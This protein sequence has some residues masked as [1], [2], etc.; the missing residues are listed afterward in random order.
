M[1]SRCHNLLNPS[2]H[3]QHKDK[4]IIY[5]TLVSSKDQCVIIAGR[6]DISLG[7]AWKHYISHNKT[8]K[9]LTGS[10]HLVIK[11]PSSVTSA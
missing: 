1:D 3:F 11:R 5:K 4:L 7:A 6:W 8:S 2:G 10:H 9:D